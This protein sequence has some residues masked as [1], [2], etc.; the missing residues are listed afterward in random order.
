MLSLLCISYRELEC[1][2]STFMC[3]VDCTKLKMT[4]KY[5]IIYKGFIEMKDM[6]R[7][8]IVLKMST[9]WDRIGL[10][11]R[12]CRTNW[13][14]SCLVHHKISLGFT[15]TCNYY[16]MS[17][18]FKDILYFYSIRSRIYNNYNYDSNRTYNNRPMYSF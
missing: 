17:T 7:E 4:Q 13:F 3:M 8:V 12:L 15:E 9:F 14:S 1:K 11:G 2:A 10:I 5:T 6:D 16:K 18:S